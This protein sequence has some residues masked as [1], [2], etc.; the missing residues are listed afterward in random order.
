MTSA[1]LMSGELK[2]KPDRFATFVLSPF[3][4]RR[5]VHF[6][7]ICF[8]MS[9][10]PCHRTGVEQWPCRRNSLI[11]K[12]AAI[13]YPIL[14]E[15]FFVAGSLFRS[16]N[17]K[18]HCSCGMVSESGEGVVVAGCILEVL[19]KGGEFFHLDVN[20][21]KRV[22]L[23]SSLQRAIQVRRDSSSSSAL[24]GNGREED[25]RQ[26]LFQHVR[27]D[28]HRMRVCLNCCKSQCLQLDRATG[29]S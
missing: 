21:R 5:A 6:E 16:E 27:L 28:Y 10:L 4:S 24:R 11:S 3:S 2:P 29:W 23:S 22:P 18:N 9:L 17:A 26:R 13:Q 20:D 12:G 14:D 8:L 1:L 25:N 7:R 15:N 19:E